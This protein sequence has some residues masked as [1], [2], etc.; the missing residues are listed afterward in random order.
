MKQSIK[1]KTLNEGENRVS[2]K[3]D[4]P[5]N[6]NLDKKNRGKKE[7]GEGVQEFRGW[8]ATESRW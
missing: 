3:I 7:M 6:N 2:L 5:K 4:L 1:E 8:G